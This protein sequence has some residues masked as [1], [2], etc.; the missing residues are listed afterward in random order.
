MPSTS[1][2]CQHQLSTRIYADRPQ[3]GRLGGAIRADVSASVR[4]KIRAYTYSFGAYLHD[5]SR[6]GSIPD[7][8]AR[9]DGAA[10]LTHHAAGCTA[11]PGGCRVEHYALGLC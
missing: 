10:E 7:G 6:A 1:D 3:Q 11:R 9:S 4:P 5:R 8:H 2:P